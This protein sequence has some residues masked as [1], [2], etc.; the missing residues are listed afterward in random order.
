MQDTNAIKAGLFALGALIIFVFSWAWLK[1]Y[2]LF[3]A[4]QRFTARFDDVAGLSSNATVN[5]QGVRVGILEGMGFT[6]EKRIDCKIKITADD[7]VV[8]RGSRIT[9]QTLGL[10]GAKYLEIALPRDAN[11]NV[12]KNPPLQAN[13]VL[14]PLKDGGD[15]KIGL[16]ENPVRVE[17]IVNKIASRTED[18]VDS[19][20][21]QAASSAINNFSHAA[22]KLNKNMDKL[23]D[24]ADSVKTASDNIANTAGRFGRT[25]DSASAATERANVFFRDGDVAAKNVGDLARDLRGT[26]THVNKLLENPNFSSDVRETM[27]RA[28]QTAETIRG[29]IADL[30]GTLKDKNLRDDVLTS[31]TKMQTSTENISHS[32]EILNKI[33]N[34]QGLRG[35]IKEAVSNAKEAVQQ[36]SAI[37]NEPTFKTNL[38]STMT[39][40]RS[41]ADNVNVASK[42][43]QQVLDKR[44]PLFHLMFGRPGKITQKTCDPSTPCPPG[45]FKQNQSQIQAPKTIL[46]PTQTVPAVQSP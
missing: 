17:L 5:V 10:V 45:A 26:N 15:P 29:A 16:V 28:K 38:T 12:A 35:D 34:D 24:A 36:A 39:K 43:V 21:T 3:H 7:C 22:Q 13:D 37:M 32:M 1:S 40:V 44:A 8:P 11:G 18:I 14:M 46:V 6:P 19:I 9:I 4:P 23:R 33:S 42:Q 20:D 41:A 30:N 25:A 31:L 27:Q 2:S